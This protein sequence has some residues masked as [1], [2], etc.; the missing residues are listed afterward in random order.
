M[1]TPMGLKISIIPNSI[2][3]PPQIEIVFPFAWNF[4]KQNTYWV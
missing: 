4:H 3:G 2:D 1:H